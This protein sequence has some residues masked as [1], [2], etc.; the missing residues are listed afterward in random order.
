MLTSPRIPYREKNPRIFDSQGQE[1]ITYYW[2]QSYNHAL[3]IQTLQ[4][5]QHIKYNINDLRNNSMMINKTAKLWHCKII[6]VIPTYWIPHHASNICYPPSSDRC[7]N[8]CSFLAS[9]EWCE[10]S[11]LRSWQSISSSP[12]DLSSPIATWCRSLLVERITVLGAEFDR[13]LELAIGVKF[14]ISSIETHTITFYLSIS[15][16]MATI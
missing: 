14:F 7:S 12:I 10:Y 3:Y 2:L 8:G 5:K 11:R 4:A 13:H 9:P 1:I 15:Q 16:F 6:I